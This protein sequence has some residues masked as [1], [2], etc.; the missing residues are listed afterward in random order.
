MAAP[1]EP[2]LI[3]TMAEALLASALAAIEPGTNGRPER[4][5][6]TY[7]NPVDDCNNALT[8]Y[9]G[10][11]TGAPLQRQAPGAKQ[12]CAF[13]TYVDFY[14]RLVRCVRSPSGPNAKGPPPKQQQADALGLLEDAWRLW[15]GIGAAWKD[16][17]LFGDV[18]KVA[19]S[20]VIL[21]PL[22]PVPVGGTAAGWQWKITV[23]ADEVQTPPA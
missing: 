19:C 5:F 7:A 6:V 3:G 2:F 16:G 22:V 23:Q 18:Y 1:S 20:N 13:A 15:Q 8:V 10:P 12:A 11:F 21:G 9:V 4:V 14:I 17:D